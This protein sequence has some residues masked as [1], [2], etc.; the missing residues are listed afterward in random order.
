VNVLAFDCGNSRIKWGLH[1]GSGWAGT[2]VL[3]RAGLAT[4]PAALAHLPRPQRIAVSNVAGAALRAELEAQFAPLGVKPQ[5]LAA[6][7]SQCGVVNRYDNPASL[8]VDRWCAMVAAR[9]IENGAC[10]VVGAGTATTVDLLSASGEFLGG[11]IL[12]GYELMKRS[13]AQ[14]T[15]GLPFADGRQV[16]MPRNTADA[17]E[18]GVAHAQAGAVER[19]HAL[20][21]RQAGQVGR[22]ACIVSGGAAPAVARGLGVPHRVVE[23]LVL[24]GVV[25]IVSQADG[26]GHGIGGAA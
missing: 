9:A 7:A 22:V 15:A 14:N 17:I 4:L 20:L 13:L 3:P 26:Q 23:H 24:D 10:V 2:G 1:D 18:S 11:L 21:A 5:W 6:A 12:P 19:M 8:G 16:D 25:R